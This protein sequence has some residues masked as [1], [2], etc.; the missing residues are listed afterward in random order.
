MVLVRLIPL[1]LVMSPSLLV[2]VFL[3]VPVCKHRQRC[4]LELGLE[5]ELEN[6]EQANQLHCKLTVEGRVGGV[7]VSLA[8]CTSP[9]EGPTCLSTNTSSIAGFLGH[10]TGVGRA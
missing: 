5:L 1:A 8:C 10:L 6:S 4:K 3:S 7:A 2:P 9:P